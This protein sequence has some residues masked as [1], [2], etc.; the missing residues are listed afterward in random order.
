[1]GTS[2]DQ[3]RKE[4]L[5][6]RNALSAD[7]TVRSSGLIF[8][9]VRNT[10]EYKEAG[11][12]LLYASFGSEVITDML[13]DDALSAGKKV[14]LPK[15]K[16]DEMDFYRISS[17]DELINGAWNI[18]E[19]EE[20]VN[21]IFKGDKDSLILMPLVAFDRDGSRIGYG[22]GYYDRFLSGHVTGQRIGLAYSLQEAHFECEPT[23]IRMDKII[24][25]KEIIEVKI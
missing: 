12:I 1:M 5:K 4:I 8:E 11:V 13:T 25:E 2:K 17:R 3:T 20:D 16:G 9:R 19:P 24:T 23:D 7:E 22:R 21:G 6:K 15:V 10:V 18:P 14:Y